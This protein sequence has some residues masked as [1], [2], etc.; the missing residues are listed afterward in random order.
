ML[1]HCGMNSPDNFYI[2]RSVLTLNFDNQCGGVESQWTPAGQNIDASIWAFGRDFTVIS[3]SL[4]DVSYQ[5]GHLMTSKI[6]Y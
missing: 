4:Q 1:S 6:L 2:L 3:E 5:P